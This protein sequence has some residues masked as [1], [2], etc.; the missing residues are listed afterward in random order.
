MFLSIF[1]V[2]MNKQ[3]LVQSFSRASIWGRLNCLVLYFVRISVGSLCKSKRKVF[4][5][6]HSFFTLSSLAEVW[7]FFYIKSLWPI[8]LILLPSDCLFRWFWNG[9]F[10]WE[11]QGFPPIHDLAMGFVRCFWAEW[12][13]TN[14]HLVHYNT[15]APPITSWPITSLLK[16]FRSWKEKKM[17]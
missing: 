9:H 1:Q 11:Y 7:V 2:R 16:N 15:Q 12:R 6:R 10:W 8:H 14:E 13:V 5:F 17:F 4:S 3:F